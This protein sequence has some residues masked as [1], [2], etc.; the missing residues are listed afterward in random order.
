ME[1]KQARK[2]LLIE[3]QAEQPSP[4]RAMFDRVDSSAFQAADVESIC[5]AE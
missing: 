5:D 2:V 1:N 3:D 4:I